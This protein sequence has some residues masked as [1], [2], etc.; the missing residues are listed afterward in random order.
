MC[1][2]SS[3]DASSRY[4]RVQTVP[5]PGGT[6]VPT[7]PS[8][9][10]RG[11]N[12]HARDKRKSREHGV[13]T[14]PAVVISSCPG[15]RRAAPHSLRMGR[16]G[17]SRGFD[18]ASYRRA[19]RWVALQPCL[20]ACVWGVCGWRHWRPLVALHLPRVVRP[21]FPLVLPSLPPLPPCTPPPHAA[22]CT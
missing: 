14:R 2:V 4:Q 22:R 6:M 17:L 8:S 11:T 13:V 7:I 12:E 21:L 1:G 9:Q 20:G 18:G 5:Y 10:Q 3:A 16:A 19:A 15:L